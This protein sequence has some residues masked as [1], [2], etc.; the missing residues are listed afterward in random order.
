[1]KDSERT[2]AE[3]KE[4]E[5]STSLDDQSSKSPTHIWTSTTPNASNLSAENHSQKNSQNSQNH[6]KNSQKNSTQSSSTP[7]L[8]SKRSSQLSSE[9]PTP[10]LKSSS[11]SQVIGAC[12]K[13]AKAVVGDVQVQKYSIEDQV[14]KTSFGDQVQKTSVKDLLEN[15]K[16]GEL[17][18]SASLPVPEVNSD[19][20]GYLVA[21]KSN[22][23]II[24]RSKIN[25]DNHNQ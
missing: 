13:Y 21:I 5:S 15:T 22:T 8:A 3:S 4:W 16:G 17:K 11:R 12:P 23:Q 1:M 7:S 6:S 9:S 25:I 10:S 24:M 2:I 14:Q 18:D 19:H 20:Q